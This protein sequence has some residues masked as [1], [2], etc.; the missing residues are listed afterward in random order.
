MLSIHVVDERGMS[1]PLP[2]QIEIRRIQDVYNPILSCSADISAPFHNGIVIVGRDLEY[3]H[4]CPHIKQISYLFDDFS[5]LNVD[6][7]HLILPSSDEYLLHILGG[8]THA[9]E[10]LHLFMSVNAISLF[11]Q[12]QVKACCI[13]YVPNGWPS[14][15]RHMH[16]SRAKSNNALLMNQDLPN[17]PLCGWVGFEGGISLKFG[18]VE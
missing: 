2:Y 4:F 16:S 14:P 18:T 17:R 8:K 3:Q 9:T 13:R 7:E 15:Q 11:F 1:V 10:V 12:V 6:C 5:L